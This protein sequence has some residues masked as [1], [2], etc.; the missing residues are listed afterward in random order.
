MKQTYTTFEIGEFCAVYPTTVINW[1]REKKLPAFVTPGGHRRVRREDLIS[2]LNKYSFP[3]P[4]EL[5]GARR[6]ILIVDDDAAFCRMIEKAFKR[7]RG[8]FETKVILTDVECVIRLRS[9]QTQGVRMEGTAM[10]VSIEYLQRVASVLRSFE[11][12][13]R[14]DLSPIVDLGKLFSLLIANAKN[15][16]EGRTRSS[17]VNRG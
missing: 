6:R 12:D 3:M 10:P 15:A 1:I 7:H 11:V 2:F 8:V 13:P 4:Q 17:R 5:S 9:R 14:V 16:V